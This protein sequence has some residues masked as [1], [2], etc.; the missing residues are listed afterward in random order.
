MSKPANRTELVRQYAAANT[1]VRPK[2]VASTLGMTI[3][4]ACAAIG[5]LQAQGRLK[6]KSYGLYE[7]LPERNTG[8]EAPI[9]DRLWRAMRINPVWSCADIA[10][11]AGTTVSYVY[12]RLRDYRAEGYVKPSGQ[13]VVPCGR[14]KLWRLSDKGRALLERPRVEEFH[15]DPLVAAATGLNKLI[16]TGRARRFQDARD[17]ALGLCGEILCALND[18]DRSPVE[19]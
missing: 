10:V 2:D 11:Q 4:Q 12:K 8:R 3:D 5:T 14:V 15:P 16:C 13:K 6:R 19:P 7:W 1:F 17:A 18:L 9:E